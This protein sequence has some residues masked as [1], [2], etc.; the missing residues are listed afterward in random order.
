LPNTYVAPR[1]DFEQEL[2]KIWQDILDIR[3]IGI[4]D[5]FFE[6][7]GHSLTASQVI[8][9]VIQAFQLELPIKA[10]FDAPTVAEMAVI[11]GQNQ[12]KRASDEDLTQMLREVEA[13]TEEEALRRVDEMNSTIADK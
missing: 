7:G 13:M 12:A 9:R 2:L 6:L 1:T 10:L 8:S 3:P 11:I 5:N 4:H